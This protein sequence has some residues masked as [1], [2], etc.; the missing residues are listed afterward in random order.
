MTV[1][2]LIA[3]LQEMPEDMLVYDNGSYIAVNPEDIFIDSMVIGDNDEDTMNVV[4]I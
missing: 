1:K 4:F 3:K 2:E